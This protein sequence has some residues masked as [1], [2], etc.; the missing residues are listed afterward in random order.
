MDST[1]MK[2]EFYCSALTNKRQC[3]LLLVGESLTSQAEW[4][5]KSGKI[6]TNS[7]YGLASPA[8]I[9]LR[10]FPSLS[11]SALNFNLISLSSTPAAAQGWL[12]RWMLV[13][14]EA[15]ITRHIID[16]SE[17]IRKQL[18]ND[19]N[20]IIAPLTGALAGITIPTKWTM[21]LV[22]MPSVTSEIWEMLSLM[23]TGLCRHP[24]R[25][26][27]FLYSDLAASSAAPLFCTLAPTTSAKP[28]TPTRRKLE[29]L[30][31][32]P[33][34]VSLEFC[35]Y[36]CRCGPQFGLLCARSEPLSNLN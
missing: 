31:G 19:I 21:A 16:S 3:R 11:N 7:V 22:R 32:A 24:S 12:I 13:S 33:L 26:T 6:D 10:A 17:L 28:T 20:F 35:K 27:L 36:S 5:V 15:F 1:S 8:K 25:T 2:S 14:T 30:A 9:I 4:L 18:A 34:A 29:T 23:A